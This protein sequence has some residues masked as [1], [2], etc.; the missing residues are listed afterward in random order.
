[1]CAFCRESIDGP[2]ILVPCGHFWD[3]E[4]LVDLFRAATVDETLFPPRCCQQP[5]LL[6]IVQHYLGAEMLVTF[7]RISIEFSTIDRVYCHRPTC[8]AFICPATE[9][10]STQI[11]PKCFEQTCGR[12]KEQAHHGASCT[13]DDAPILAMAKEEGW[14]RCPGCK[15]LVELT[16]GCYHITC[17]C[18]K[19]FCYIC[20]EIWKNCTCPQ[21]DEPRLLDHAR[22]RVQRELPAGPPPPVRQYEEMV[23]Q[24]A[25]R[26]RVDHDCQHA[27]RYRQGGGRCEH[28]SH[29]LPKFLFVR[30]SDRAVALLHTN[31]I[32]ETRIAYIVV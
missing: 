29:Y 19:Q 6:D 30:R 1:M 9:T 20:A 24:T 31:D 11:C 22:D 18:G 28:C 12:C 21:W 2:Q 8:S 10:P 17:R 4:C 26:L 15:H 5:I 16:I 25:E 7:N 3:V 23:R 32:E 13:I 27:W 14:A